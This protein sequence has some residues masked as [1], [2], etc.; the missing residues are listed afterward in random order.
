MAIACSTSGFRMPLEQ[1][2]ERVEALGF[3]HVDLITMAGWQHVDIAALADS[4]D[5]ESARIQRLLGKHRLTPVAMNFAVGHPHDRTNPAE[6][7]RRLDL[8]AGVCRMMNAIGVKVASFYPGRKVENRPWQDVL[9]GTVKS[10]GEM[11]EQAQKFGVR[12]VVEPHFAT[13]FQTVEQCTGLL[14][15]IPELNVAFDPSHFAMQGIGMDAVK[16][17]FARASH[18]HVRDAGPDK[19]QMPFGKGTVD[20]A[21]MAAG[22]KSA[23]FKGNY[24]IEYL[25]GLEDGDVEA[26]I[27]KLKSWLEKNA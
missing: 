25:P 4:F 11:L 3:R 14:N 12:L 15:A 2:L 26:E 16:F 22:L 1:A 24:S 17:L 13:P 18:V 20:F 9:E 8:A 19:M 5:A 7:K 21:A 27:V 23:G 6:V 10:V